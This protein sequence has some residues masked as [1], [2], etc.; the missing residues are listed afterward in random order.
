MTED[1]TSANGF[2]RLAVQEMWPNEAL[3]FTPWLAK[4]LHLLEDATGMKL[5][6]VQTEK[7]VGS[8]FLDILARDANTG[9]L[10][11]IENLYGWTDVDHL[12]RLFIYAAGC[13]ARVSIL[14]AEE[15]TYEHAQTLHRMNEWT[16]VNVGFY[17]VK[18]WLEKTSEESKPRPRF[19]KVVYPGGWDKEATLPL[20]STPPNILED[21]R[22]HRIF[23]QPIIDDLMGRN[24]A[25]RVVQNWSHTDRMFRSLVNHS[26]G[27]EASLAENASWVTLN[28]RMEDKEQANRIY[29]ELLS[30]RDAIEAN[31]D[32]GPF[33]GW[34]WRR[35]DGYAFSSISVR[36]DGTIDDPP[37]KLAEIRK[38]MS[39]LLVRFKEVFDPRVA[40]IVERLSSD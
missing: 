39:D 40:E 4:N 6:L 38:W 16:R 2:E 1:T 9:T 26:I 18:M 17:A 21:R 12:G 14:I 13:N 19:L 34:D 22:K 29:D 24:F 7:N 20:S 10:V 33:E 30:Q 5:E 15:F 35:Y 36:R 23:F 31:I 8:L 37:E 25:D 3:H 28:I 27:Y 32:I 11:A